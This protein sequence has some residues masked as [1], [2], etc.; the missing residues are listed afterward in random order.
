MTVVRVC[1]LLLFFVFY[2]VGGGVVQI[3]RQSSVGTPRDGRR[4]GSGKGEVVCSNMSSLGT[5]V[6]LLQGN[7]TNTEQ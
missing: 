2:L 6:C 5:T 3:P 1:V 4:E 7:R